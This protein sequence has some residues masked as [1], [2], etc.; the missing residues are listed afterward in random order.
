[1]NAE[2]IIHASERMLTLAKRAIVSDE[3]DTHRTAILG[4][5]G[6]M[7]T[8]LGKIV[9][10]VGIP[11]WSGVVM[12]A[13][14]LHTA[15]CNAD[16][17]RAGAFAHAPSEMALVS[18]LHSFASVLGF[19]VADAATAPT[20]TEDDAAMTAVEGARMEAAE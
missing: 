8:D 7:S 6:T 2:T 11:I 9:V 16:E 13:Y 17:R 20:D 1:M 18:A 19:R 5:F 10:A 15:A 3:R 12:A 14:D 4:V